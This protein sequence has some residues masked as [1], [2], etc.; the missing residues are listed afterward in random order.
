MPNLNR[1]IKAQRGNTSMPAFQKAYKEIQS[2]AKTSHWIWYIFP[3]LKQLGSSPMAKEYGIVDFK[4]AC[5]YLQNEELFNNYHEITQLVL[6]QLTDGIPV[7]RLM[8]SSIDVH[9]LSSS[10]TL[11]REAATFLV[12]QQD[13]DQNYERLV[14]CCEQLLTILEPC[15]KT[16]AAIHKRSPANLR[17]SATIDN[18]A[19]FNKT[20]VSPID[21]YSALSQSLSDY[22]EARNKEW[23]FHYNFLGI[24]SVVYWLNDAIWGTNYFNT[25]SR[26]IKV[27]AATHL[28]KMIDHKD[29]DSIILSEAEETALR[30]GTLGDLINSHGGLDTIMQSLKANKDNNHVTTITTNF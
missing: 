18:S 3:Q 29:Y 1:F 27:S 8:G 12:K 28:K 13:S 26:E 9:K 22:I 20:I 5:D 14:N 17:G 4:E 21:D 2:G 16:L 30:N 19:V 24:M 23:S 25:K 6:E 15:K 7:S 11:F 10:L